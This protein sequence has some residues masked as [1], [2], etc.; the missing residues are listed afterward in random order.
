[1]D[2]IA[3]LESVASAY[4]G[5]KTLSVEILSVEESGDNASSRRSEIRT[6][7]WFEAPNKIRIEREGPHG[8]VLAT[9]GVDVHSFHAFPKRYS[10]HPGFPARFLPGEFLPDHAS[11]FVNPPAFLFSKI[12][13]HVKSAEILADSSASILASVTYNEPGHPL[14]RFTS[15]VL[16]SIDF[17]TRLVSRV[18]GEVTIRMPA[19]DHGVSRKHSV[20]FVNTV[21]DGPVSPDIFNFIPPPDA[22][23]GR[24]PPGTGWRFFGGGG[25][26]FR[27]PGGT[28]R[29][30]HRRS[31]NWEGDTLVEVYTLRAHGMDLT[32]ERRITFSED[33]RKLDVTERIVG[34]A[35]EAIHDLSLPL[36]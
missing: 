32:F 3:V 11:L 2:A 36:A 1:M 7:A 23:E 9:D 27:G 12:A 13:R 28:D 20:S 35:G 21:V 18:E 34:P 29:F 30:E 14:L 31:H 4:A 24:L 6:K 22:S 5:L 33:R 17:K 8:M 16:Y 15:P 10:K 25:S 26:A 19:R